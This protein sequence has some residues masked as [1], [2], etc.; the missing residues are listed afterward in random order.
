MH[1]VDAGNFLQSSFFVCAQ[2]VAAAEAHYALI[3][4]I[5][6]QFLQQPKFMKPV[7]NKLLNRATLN[8]S[9]AG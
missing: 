3:C 7:T 4:I 2:G 9:M 5:T 6:K 8:C 1:D